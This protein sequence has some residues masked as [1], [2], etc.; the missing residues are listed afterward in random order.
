MEDL[1]CILF[2]GYYMHIEASWYDK[3]SVAILE[4]P[5]ML[6]TSSCQ[7]TLYYHMKGEHCGSLLVYINSGDSV[8]LVFNRTGPQGDNWIRG[9]IRLKSDYGFRVHITALRGT[10]YKGD[11]A[12][13]DIS[14]QVKQSR[15]SSH[16]V[17]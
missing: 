17:H 15:L 6:P 1:L 14:F 11:I 16:D 12:I 5:Y 8:Q 13:D 9:I 10:S 7:M 3:G 4:S 2:P